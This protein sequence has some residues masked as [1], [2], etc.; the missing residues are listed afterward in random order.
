M[1]IF[2]GNLFGNRY[3]EEMALTWIPTGIFVVVV[4]TVMWS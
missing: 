4:G 2:I 3:E 1:R